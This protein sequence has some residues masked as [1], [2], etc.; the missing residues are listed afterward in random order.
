MLHVT[1]Q[2]RMPSIWETRVA[3]ITIYSHLLQAVRSRR[4][5]TISQSRTFDTSLDVRSRLITLH[6]RCDERMTS[7]LLESPFHDDECNFSS[8]CN[9]SKERGYTGWWIAHSCSLHS[10]CTLTSYL[11]WIPVPVYRTHCIGQNAM[12]HMYINIHYIPTIPCTFMHERPLTRGSRITCL[13]SLLLLFW[14]V[15]YKLHFILFYR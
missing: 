2:T 14:L 12:G 13:N 4:V 7:V 5:C 3:A 10:A 9:V 11:S 15:N 6:G 8:L 1:W